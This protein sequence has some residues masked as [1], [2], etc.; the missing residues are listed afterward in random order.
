MAVATQKI[1][2]WYILGGLIVPVAM[3]GDAIWRFAGGPGIGIGWW[4]LIL[5][6]AVLLMCAARP[7]H[8]EA[9]EPPEDVECLKCGQKLNESEPR[10]SSCG[11][12]WGPKTNEAA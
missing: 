12:S 6:D 10:C 3:V 4:L 7:P 5:F 11:W 2:V 1:N 8:I 9:K